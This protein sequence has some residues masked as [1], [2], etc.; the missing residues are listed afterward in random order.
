M[1]PYAE[2]TVD[3]QY[4]NL[5]KDILERGVRSQS[6]AGT[7]AATPEGTDCI[8][9]FGANPMRFD[10]TNGFPLITERSVKGFWK[11]AIGEIIGFANGARTQKELEEHAAL[12][13][14]FPAMEHEEPYMAHVAP[15]KTGEI[16]WNF[17]RAGDFDFA[18]LIAGHFQAGMKGKIK[19]AAK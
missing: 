4:K 16:I 2:R 5:L 13:L 3:L 17:N 9:L 19:V 6:Q 1:K 14:K 8:T 12:M 15:D 7:T 10:L 18:C 11:Q